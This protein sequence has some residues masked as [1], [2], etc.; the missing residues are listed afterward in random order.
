MKRDSREKFLLFRIRAFRDEQAFVTLLEK[1]ASSLQRLLYFKLPNQD[2][3]DDVYSQVCIRLWQYIIRTPVDHFSGLAHTIA[4]TSIAEFYRRR[5]GKEQV[6]IDSSE[7]HDQLESKES[8]ER[9]ESFVDAGIMK[10]GLGELPDDDR[11]AVV[12][13]HLEG[14]S[15]KEIAKHLGKTE[16]ATSVLI[17][18]ALKKLRKILESS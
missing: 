17:Y 7:T 9:I 6:S 3:V 4:R 18:R 1:H 5:E 2:D 13:R 10:E 14:Y 11:E 12:M 8:G 16:N 15:V